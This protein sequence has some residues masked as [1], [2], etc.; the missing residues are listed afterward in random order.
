MTEGSGSPLSLVAALESLGDVDLL[1]LDSDSALAVVEIVQAATSSISA[2][3]V[4]AHRFK[5]SSGWTLTLDTDG[6]CTWTTPYRAPPPHPS[7][8]SRRARRLTAGSPAGRN[9]RA[10]PPVARS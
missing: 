9:A 1:S 6:T 4:E 8:V 7:P 5:H 2:L 3:A 10:A